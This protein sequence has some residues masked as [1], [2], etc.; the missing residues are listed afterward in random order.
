MMQQHDARESL[1]LGPL[2]QRRQ[3]SALFRPKTPGGDKGGGRH[4][5]RQANQRDAPAPAQIGKAD[6][7]VVAAAPGRESLVQQRH[8]P[9]DIGVVVAGRKTHLLRSA[10]PAEPFPRQ[11]DLAAKANIDDIAGHRDM[12]GLLREE[13]FDEPGEQRHIV[14]GGALAQPV[15][16]A[17]GSL[18]QKLREIRARNWADMGVGE[19]GEKE[20]H[21]A[22]A[23]PINTPAASTMAPP[24]TI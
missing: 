20:T 1:R 4:A 23:P 16:I 6:R 12:I 2:Q 5:R 9:R 21:A 3:I 14:L 22:H 13:I 10:E 17:G 7:A 24:S 15:H 18:A 8:G 11:G 19:M